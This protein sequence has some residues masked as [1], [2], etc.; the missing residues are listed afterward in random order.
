MNSS[1]KV[2]NITKYETNMPM[3]IDITVEADESIP[4]DEMIE[5]L[6]KPIISRKKR[7]LLKTDKGFP[8]IA[9]MR[10]LRISESNSSGPSSEVGKQS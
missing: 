10:T 6:S 1:L 9:Q 4:D 2:L 7:N 3:H 8:T 5:A